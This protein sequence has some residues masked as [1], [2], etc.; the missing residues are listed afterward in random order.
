MGI[1]LIRRPEKIS[2]FFLGE[3]SWLLQWL[4]IQVIIN[5][6]ELTRRAL[7]YV[8]QKHI[9]GRDSRDK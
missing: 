6:I 2:Q 8:S 3:E 9:D 4:K 5:Q 1:Y 7:I